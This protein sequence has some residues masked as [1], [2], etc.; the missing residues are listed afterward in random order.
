MATLGTFTEGS[1]NQ[2]SFLDLRLGIHLCPL[3]GSS[4]DDDDDNDGNDDVHQSWLQQ[5]IAARGVELLRLVA[6]KCKI[7]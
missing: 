1:A 4:T 5:R 2:V 7:N 3:H 6:T